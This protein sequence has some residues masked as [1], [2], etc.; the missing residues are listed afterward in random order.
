MF[1]AAVLLVLVAVLL[2]AARNRG[3]LA[4]L[5]FFIGTLFPAIGFFNV[6][7]FRF[8]FV[9]DHFQYLASLEPITLAL[10]GAALLLARWRVWGRK[11]GKAL[12]PALLVA[13]AGLTWKQS[14]MYVDDETVWARDNRQES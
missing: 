14:A 4:A 8:S 10:A 6:Y 7:P 3:P 13:L 12:W 2:L 1:P 11:A 9:A 5:L